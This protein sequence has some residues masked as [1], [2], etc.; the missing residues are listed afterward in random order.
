MGNVQNLTPHPIE[1]SSVER[2][3][4]LK[5]RGVR[6]SNVRLTTRKSLDKG[7]D[8]EKNFEFHMYLYT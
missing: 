7:I 8:I 5:P 3:V 1:F 4:D 6:W 2:I